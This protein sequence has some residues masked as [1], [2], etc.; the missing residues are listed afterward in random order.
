MPTVV[1]SR[2]TVIGLHKCC[3]IQFY[4]TLVENSHCHCHSTLAKMADMEVEAVFALIEEGK[5]YESG[6]K[7]WW[8]ATDCFIRSFMALRTLGATHPANNEEGQNIVD[9]YNAKS[10]EFERR[11]RKCLIKALEA[12]TAKGASYVSND[13]AKRRLEHFAKLFSKPALLN[14]PPDR[15]IK[16]KQ[17]SIEERLAQLSKDLPKGLKTDDE[18]L[19]DLNKGLNRLGLSLYPNVVPTTSKSVPGIAITPGKS[20]SEQVDDII[21]QAQDEVALEAS[22]KKTNAHPPEAS[23]TA[24]GEVTDTEKT[25]EKQVEDLIAQ[26]QDEV[27][28]EAAMEKDA[29]GCEATTDA[30]KSEDKA[31]IA[32]AQVEGSNDAAV[33]Q[34]TIE[35]VEKAAAET[36]DNEE[37]K[38][39]ESAGEDAEDLTPETV[40]LVQDTA[41]EAQGLLAEF[42]ALLE[43]SKEETDEVAE[44]G[45]TNSCL[46]DRTALR[47]SLKQVR[48]LMLKAATELN[49]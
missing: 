38:W 16:K 33:E 29:T 42:L 37:L 40:S 41:A 31:A 21:A 27:A 32:T 20:E 24:A 12:E 43:A 5:K 8:K 17:E 15:S 47:E 19:R 14:P 48:D 23:D 39:T 25:E 13:E 3:S 22:L 28:K 44:K 1:D 34:T 35:S 30:E 9:L 10:R 18:R 36:A 11:A 7:S 4:C 2:L 45:T 49:K 46:L 6:K 26:A